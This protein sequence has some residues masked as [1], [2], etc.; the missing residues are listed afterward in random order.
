MILPSQLTLSVVRIPY[1]HILMV[2]TNR[3][4]CC[5]PG[6]WASFLYV[7]CPGMDF[8]ISLVFWFVALF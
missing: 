6:M 8:C 7:L 1:L 4:G 2:L 3:F 5:V